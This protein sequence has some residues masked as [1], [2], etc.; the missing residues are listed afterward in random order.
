MN[1]E[2]ELKLQS[3]LDGELP[4]REA[5]QVEGLTQADPAAR[6][7]FGELQTTRAALRGNELERTLPESREFY[8]SKIE[9]AI[10]AAE[11]A[12]ERR[13]SSFG[14]GWLV[15][16][17]PQFSGAAVAV[18]LLIAGATQFNWFSSPGWDEI[19]NTLDDSGSFTFRS[20]QNRM[21]LVWV[22][23]HPQAEQD[24]D[25]ELVN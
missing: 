3:Y 24:E 11:Q 25:G 16:Y 19:E 18:V 4:A 6:A 22:S 1:T 17:W 10:L 12:G 7:L 2:I 15:R 23:S 14:L 5:K 8:W 21:T 9:R 13:A 20:E